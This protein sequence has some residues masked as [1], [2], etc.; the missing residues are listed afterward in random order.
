ML[1]INKIDVYYGDFQALSEVSLEV[2][3]MEIVALIGGNGAGKTTLLKTISNI[4]HPVQGTTEFQSQ[5]IDQLPAFALPHL[6]I[7]HVP[8]ERGI[9]TSMTVSENLDLGA[10]PLYAKKEKNK[11]REWV[12]RLFPV[13]KDR[14]NQV[15]GTL[16]GGEQ[17]MLAIAR[18]LMLK[19]R[20]LLVDEPSLGLAPRVFKELFG[21]LKRINEEGISVLLVE[22]NV[23]QVLLLA[24]RGYVLQKGRVVLEGEGKKL[25]QDRLVKKAYLGIL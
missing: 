22:Q 12:F 25:L 4:I 3:E 10:T 8:E 5:R 7:A 16:S 24:D 20:L 2:R 23:R 6:G 1:R 15:A 17:Q 18:G 21:T 13:L 19:P 9:F 14:K 11:S